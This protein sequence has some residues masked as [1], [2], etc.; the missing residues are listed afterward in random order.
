MLTKIKIFLIHKTVLVKILLT[1]FFRT[2]FQGREIITPIY[3]PLGSIKNANKK[4]I[5]CLEKSLTS[6]ENADHIT[7]LRLLVLRASYNYSLENDDLAKE[8]LES[9]I[10]IATH[11]R[12]TYKESDQL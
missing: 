10:K 8:D 7:L 2:S 6:K 12:S 5:V 4:R 9:I 11:W 3:R 1:T